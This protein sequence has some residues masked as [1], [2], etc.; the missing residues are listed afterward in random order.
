MPRKTKKA[1]DV[2]IEIVYLLDGSHRV[3]RKALRYDLEDAI[4]KN[5]KGKKFIIGPNVFI[6]DFVADNVFPEKEK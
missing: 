6:E 1:T 4:W 5:T 3:N 2:R